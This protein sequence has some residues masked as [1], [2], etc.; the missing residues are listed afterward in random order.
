M[1]DI[2]FFDHY[3]QEAAEKNTIIKTAGVVLAVILCLLT[4]VMTYETWT[5]QKKIANVQSQLEDSSLQKKLQEAEYIDN[6]SAVLNETEQDLNAIINAVDTRDANVSQALV[7]ISKIM[8]KT[9]TID[10]MTIN[11][12]TVS[13]N[14]KGVTRQ[15][16]AE[17][18]HNLKELTLFVDV[19]VS[20]IQPVSGDSNGFSFQIQCQRGEQNYEVE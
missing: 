10:Q 5:V 20:T 1:Q 2:N 13:L 7:L 3:R 11:A 15:A 4:L 6:Q 12:T 18:Q 14:G 19:Y 8:P 17:F 9:V 16:I